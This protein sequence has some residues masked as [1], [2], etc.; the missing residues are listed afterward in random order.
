[1]VLMLSKHLTFRNYKQSFLMINQNLNFHPLLIF[2]LKEETK[3][4]LGYWRKKTKGGLA[5]S[6]TSLKT[7]TNDLSE[8]FS[9][10]EM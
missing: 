5:F 10:F 7:N 3:I 2:L 9:M 1:M 8:N 6:K 4:I